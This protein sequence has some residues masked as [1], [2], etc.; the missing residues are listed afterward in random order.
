MEID[1]KK[2]QISG[3]RGMNMSKNKEKRRGSG[4]VAATLLSILWL[5]VNYYIYYPAIN[6]QNPEFWTWLLFHSVIIS[7]IF[8]FSGIISR[9]RKVSLKKGFRSNLEY[10]H[11][12]TGKI[13]LILLVVIPVFCVLVLALGTITSATIFNAKRYAGLLTVEQRDFTADIPE[14]ENVDN[15]ALMDTDSARIFGNRKIGSLSDVVSQFEVEKDY[16]QINISNKP[17]KVANLRYADFFKY[18]SNRKEGIPGYVMVNPVDSTAK[19]VKLEQGMKYVPSG[20]LNDN[21]Y[22]Y[23]Q[24]HNPTRIIDGCYFEV[25]DE[26]QPY[27]VCP[28]LHA[29]VGLFGGMDVKGAVLCNPVNGEMEYYDVADIPSWVDRVFDGELLEDKF[30][31]YGLLSN[32]YWNSVI[33]QKGCIQTTDD[34]GYKTIEDDVWI[35]TGVTSVTGDASNVGFVMVNQRTSEAR[36]YSISGAEEYSAMS[37]AEGEVQEKNYKASFPSLINVDGIPT[38]VMVLTDNGGL[39]KMYAMVNVEQYNLVVTAE[40]QEEVFA[41]YRKLLAKD[42]NIGETASDT[43]EKENVIREAAFEVADMEYITVEG[44]TYVYIKDE[45][46][47]VYKQKF[48]EDEALI[49]ISVGDTVSIQYEEMENGIHRIITAELVKKGINQETTEEK[50]PTT[51]S[52]TEEEDSSI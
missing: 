21:I 27:Y 49:K 1:M 45:S 10:F 24:I 40:T 41:K 8:I 5:G 42:G 15:I 31:W 51:E 18:L 20:Y 38:Y 14:S 17:M 2:L 35:Y 26:G 48:S 50:R 37:S 30:N 12:G 16:T 28:V 4:Y 36:Y 23:V 32:G 11:R 52:K 19:Y 33:G 43:A 9:S 46:G 7:C 13:Q 6:L 22:R 3:K 34:Y 39:V 29:R 47:N 25:D 44:E